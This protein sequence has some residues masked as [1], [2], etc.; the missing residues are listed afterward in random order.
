M[1]VALLAGYAGSRDKV[2]DGDVAVAM[3]QQ[4]SYAIAS[5]SETF[6]ITAS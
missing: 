4:C 1:F 3:S 2:N 5:S 6:T